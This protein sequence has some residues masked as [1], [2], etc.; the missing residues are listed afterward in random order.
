M[1]IE[2]RM[3]TLVQNADHVEMDG[4]ESMEKQAKE[5]DMVQQARY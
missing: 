1:I 4:M 5:K 2:I 3:K